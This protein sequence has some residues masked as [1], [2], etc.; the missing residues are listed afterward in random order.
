MPPVSE[1]LFLNGFIYILKGR[2][3]IKPGLVRKGWNRWS[4]RWAS[5]PT[6]LTSLVTNKEMYWETFVCVCVPF[7]QSQLECHTNFV[8]VIIWPSLFKHQQ[9]DSLPE[10]IPMATRHSPWLCWPFIFLSHTAFWGPKLHT[11]IFGHTQTH[12]TCLQAPRSEFIWIFFFIWFRK[13]YRLFKLKHQL[14]VAHTC[15]YIFMTAVLY[16]QLFYVNF[17]WNA[18]CIFQRMPVCV[19]AIDGNSSVKWCRSFQFWFVSL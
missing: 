5:S 3:V 13:I 11:G 10:T 19:S 14:H 2:P 9:K 6:V 16:Q 4:S 7:P 17:E 12:C 18:S 1:V 8:L 15:N